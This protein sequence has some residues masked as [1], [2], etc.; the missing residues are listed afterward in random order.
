[1]DMLILLFVGQ[2][3]YGNHQWPLWWGLPVICGREE[4]LIINVCSI[5]FLVAGTAEDKLRLFL[6]YYILSQDIP[7]VRHLTNTI[8]TWCFWCVLCSCSKKCL[9]SYLLLKWL[10]LILQQWSTS[11]NGSECT[12]L[13]L[14]KLC[15]RCSGCR[16]V[17]GICK[18]GHQPQSCKNGIRSFIQLCEVCMC[19]LIRLTHTMYGTVGP[20]YCFCG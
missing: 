19:K 3:S 7:E 9:R 6:I 4:G 11:K 14:A 8:V 13:T 15:H 16:C 5:L 2:V 18:D 12:A 1:M 10:V 20:D 17:Q